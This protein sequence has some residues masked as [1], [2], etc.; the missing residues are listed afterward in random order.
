M[1]M[2]KKL[3]MVIA[4]A[5][6][7]SVPFVAR[8]QGTGI[9][10]F[11]YSTFLQAQ[12]QVA[13]QLEQ[14]EHM[15]QDYM[16]QYQKYE[17]MLRNTIAPTAYTW[18]KIQETANKLENYRQKIETFASNFDGNLENYFDKFQNLSYY[19]GSSCWNASGECSSDQV[20]QKRQF[21]EEKS[22]AQFAVI[23]ANV[24]SLA[25]T[26]K[27]GG[28]IEK[29]LQTIDQLQKDA[30]KA[31]NDTDGG[32][33]KVLQANNQF[34]AEILR[35]Q[36]ELRK[37]IAQQNQMIAMQKQAELDN[38][39][40]AKAIFQNREQAGFEAL[41]ELSSTKSSSSSGAS[42]TYATTGDKALDFGL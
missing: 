31:G 27:E 26:L 4:S 24:R 7:F 41:R 11:D 13:G 29:D 14:L 20:W 21:E 18:S 30:E 17:N 32:M 5:M 33:L 38:S 37:I 36:V 22:N 10:T 19:S 15:V 12:E 6:L 16:L 40:Q 25:D 9:P 39:A 3:F 35:Q 8:A 2:D 42:Q 34:Q 28:S 1:K 23:Q